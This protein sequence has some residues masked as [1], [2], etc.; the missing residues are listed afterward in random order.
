L[1]DVGHTTVIG[2]TG[3]GK[4]VLMNFLCAQARKFGCRLFFF[5]KDRGAE[6]FI[7][8]MGGSYSIL[9]GGHASGFNPLQLPDT[10]ENRAFLTEWL[11]SLIT[12]LGE[13]FTSEDLVAITQAVNGNYK[14]APEDRTLAKI[15]PF[16]GLAGPGTPAG[17]LAMWHS[18]GPYRNL[19]G[20]DRDILSLG[21]GVTGFEMGPILSDRQCLGPVLLYLFHR[22]HLVLDGTPTMI[23]LDEAWALLDNPIFAP[24][25]KD[26]LKT[27]RKLNAFVVF[28]TQSVE[29]ASKSSISDTLVQQSATQIY[30]PNA[31][32]TEAYQTVFKL[33][34]R[35]LQLVRSLDPASRSFLIKQGREAV[36]AKLDLSEMKDVISVLSGRAENVAKLDRIRTQVGD[37]RDE[38]SAWLPLYLEE[39]H[40]SSIHAA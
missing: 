6:I 2:P 19:F 5:D 28:A 7:R 16:L 38:P 30:L 10:P 17:R 9:G 29:D 34:D 36:I 35:Q 23:V 39:S 12:T 14:L 25:I 11:Q 8:A 4:T 22:I 3:S 27:L 37:R 31:K 40:E 33:S 21:N 24:K 20:S 32:A 26:W 1:G 13:P 18:D 15:A